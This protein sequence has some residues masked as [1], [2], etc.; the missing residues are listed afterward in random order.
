MQR[1]TSTEF[2]RQFGA[3]LAAAKRGPVTVTTQGREDVVVLD[4]AE[5]T[6]L[7][8]LDT[9]QHLYAGELP[10]D[11]AAAIAAAPVCGLNLTD[12]LTR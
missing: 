12:A 10:D 7:K 3:A 2:Q 4:A 9:P 8:R 5:Y 6:R 11:I 1:I